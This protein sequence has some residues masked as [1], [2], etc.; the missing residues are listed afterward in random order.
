[1]L[2]EHDVLIC[3]FIVIYCAYKKMRKYAYAK[4][5]TYSLY[6]SKYSLTHSDVD[7]KIRRCL[8][9]ICM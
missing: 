2:N 6:T 8:S 4:T 5:R 7:R 1:M 3:R 9:I